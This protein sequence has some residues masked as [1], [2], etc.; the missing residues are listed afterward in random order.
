MAKKKI[1]FEGLI[2]SGTPQQLKAFLQILAD[3]QKQFEDILAVS[4]EMQK[5]P[6]LKTSADIKKLA[7]AIDEQNKAVEGLT[8][9]EQ[10]QAKLMQRLAELRKGELDDVI[11]LREQIKEE[12]K[13]AREQAKERLG[14]VN[15]YQQESKRLNE[16]R[17]RY[18][19]LA[20]QNKE[21]TKEGREL[22]KEIVKLDGRLKDIDKSVGQS[23][24]RV[25][26]Y[27]RAWKDLTSQIKQFATIGFVFKLIEGF[28]SAF[29]Q[30]SRTAGEFQ[31]ILGL[32]TVSLRVF[33][34]RIA[35]AIPQFKAFFTDIGNGFK[36]FFKELQLGFL[37]AG[38]LF[39]DNS[40]KIAELK[41]EIENLNKSRFDGEAFANAFK[42]I[43]DEIAETI[44][45]NNKFIDSQLRL[46]KVNAQLLEQ[47]ADLVEEIA[48][49]EIASGDNTLS[50]EER[51]IATEQLI[52]VQSQFNDLQIKIAENERRLAQQALSVNKDSIEA[53]EQLAQ[54]E[55][56]LAEARAQA[57]TDLE[58]GLKEARD[59]ESDDIERNLDFI[60]DVADRRKTINE[61]II[62][63]ET[64]SF[65]TRRK[66][67]EENQRIT[68]KL[69]ADATAELQKI[70]TETI[71]FNDLLREEDD[72]TIAERLKNAGLNDR[73]VGRGLEL[74]RE[75]IT[76]NQDLAESERD[77]TR[78]R[79]ESDRVK[80]DSILIEDALNK[81]S[82]KGVD[83]QS[84][85][86]G[87]E[88]KRLQLEID[89]LQLRL[90]SAEK[91]S[92]ERIQIEQELNEKLLEQQ[93]ARIAK[94]NKADEDR[95]AKQKELTETAVDIAQGL[96]DRQFE[97][98]SENINAEITANENRQ[99]R[100]R[101]L[102]EQGNQDA[103][104]NL[105]RD[106]QRRAELEQKR[107]RQAQRQK[108]LELGLAT[109]QAYSN[110]LG[111]GE[112]NALGSTI[113]DTTA[114]LAFVNSLPAFWDGAE[115]VSDSLTPQMSGRD[116]HI[117]RVDGGERVMTVAQNSMIPKG[118]SNWELATLAQLSTMPRQTTTTAVLDDSN[119]VNA[120]KGVQKAVDN[121][122]NYRFEYDR[123]ANAVADAWENKSRMQ[124]RSRKNRP[125]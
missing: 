46:R 49:L 120:V 6:P 64:V 74:I 53:R 72:K 56:A 87:L 94:Q 95:L 41:A 116:G 26:E 11:A 51:R 43:G 106:E 2:E 55:L 86:I 78:D 110:K 114:L 22:R 30:N 13:Q 97:A 104:Q 59:I 81:A 15:A 40:A 85:L 25:G 115:R 54:A 88:Q 19:D 91:G 117:I 112:E 28:A 82:E 118:M 16:L 65:D 47:Q 9:T 73:L 69:F 17:K 79:Q 58:N 98:Q 34:S 44:E 113:A 75:Q 23:Q 84:V 90:A 121:K 8:K 77:L 105:A 52:V 24:R 33:V 50:L 83:L 96:F 124:R 89:N 45:K 100:L 3:M 63:D 119:I 101:R 70:A 27:E 71:D 7:G 12:S 67:L 36:A 125:F 37:E 99:A 61:R 18:K 1:S 107:A 111:D 39:T 122:P 102:A 42:G 68:D 109:V 31:K 29:Q 20:V 14:L 62:A 57:Q 103:E 32:V 48:K 5:N 66:L 38:S 21:N 4:V 60:I 93:K 80:A 108:I 76:F 10:Q 35:D 92:A 123:V